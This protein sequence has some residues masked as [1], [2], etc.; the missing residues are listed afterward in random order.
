MAVIFARTRWEYASYID[1]WKVCALSSF[2]IIYVDEIN[3]KS[4]DTYIVTPLNGEWQQGWQNPRARI[5]LWDLEWHDAKPIIPGVSEVWASDVSYA[6]RNECRYV[7]LGS[8]PGLCPD[9]R[10]EPRQYDVAMIA[11]INHRRGVIEGRLK[12]DGL[13]VAPNYGAEDSRRHDILMHSRIV[14]HVHQYENIH[15]ISPTRWM[16]AAAYRLPILS[17]AI[18]R[19]GVFEYTC[20]WA[21]Y[22]NLPKMAK[23]AMSGQYSFELQE[24]SSLFHDRLC[25]E[26]TFR[27]CVENALR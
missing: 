13:R 24:L 12:N 5:V 18:D 6:N 23:L 25:R 16:T 26:Y 11:Y 2:P 4:N 10:N 17:E 19:P 14:L 7:I 15:T 9:V 1:F 8:H 22:E 21:R 20:L 3:P 27:R